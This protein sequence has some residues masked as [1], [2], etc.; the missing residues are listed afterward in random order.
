MG[1]KRRI[2][3]FLLSDL[4]KIFPLPCTNMPIGRLRD[5]GLPTICRPRVQSGPKDRKILR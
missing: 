3:F 4:F 1:K 2:S 5:T